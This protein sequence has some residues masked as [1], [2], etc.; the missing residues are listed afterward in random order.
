MADVGVDVVMEVVPVVRVHALLH[1]ML[2]TGQPLLDELLD[3]SPALAH[4]PTLLMVVHRLPARGPCLAFRGE[5]ALGDLPTLA[6]QRVGVTVK[7]VAVGL[8]PLLNVAFTPPQ[9]AACGA[10]HCSTNV[11]PTDPNHDTARGLT[12]CS[13]A[14]GSAGRHG[15]SDVRRQSLGRSHH[16]HGSTPNPPAPDAVSQLWL[17]RLFDPDNHRVGPNEMLDVAVAKARLLH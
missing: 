15:C 12:P 16:S 4:E 14:A 3:R 11:T 9:G 8:S 5:A 10:F 2:A 1:R 17:D 6:G 13:V 7:E